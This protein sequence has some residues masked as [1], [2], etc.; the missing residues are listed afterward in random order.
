MGLAPMAVLPEY[1]KRGIGSALVER[2]FDECRRIGHNIV[3]VVGHPEYYPRFGFTPAREQGLGC[4]FDVPDEVFMVAELSP[5]TL[6]GRQGLV[7][8]HPEF[9]N[10]V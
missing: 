8:Y 7:K 6:D 1:Q 5:G 4:E 2:G 10:H 9:K 3:V